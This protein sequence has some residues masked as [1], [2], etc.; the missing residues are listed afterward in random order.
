MPKDDDRTFFPYFFGPFWW[1]HVI[2]AGF[3]GLIWLAL[4]GLLIWGL[5]RL[6]S[7]R[8]SAPVAGGPWRTFGTPPTG[9]SATEILRQRYAR[10]EID[11]ETYQQMLERLQASEPSEPSAGMRL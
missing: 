7:G 4:L 10:G 2:G 1:L 9:P 3:S 8:H 6:V 5:V 11:V